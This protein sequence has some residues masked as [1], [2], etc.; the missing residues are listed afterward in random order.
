MKTV[1]VYFIILAFL[2]AN[3]TLGEL[4]KTPFL[5]EHFIEHQKRNPNLG[6]M[7]FMSMHYW[8]TDIKDN[9]QQKDMKLPFKKILHYSHHIL[10]QSTQRVLCLQK[11]TYLIKP[12]MIYQDRFV[13]HPSP[14]QLYRPPQA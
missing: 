10:F 14:D 7:E 2:C 5:G 1:G 13:Q 12:S 8:G 3:T 4:L 11:K 9:D 6:F